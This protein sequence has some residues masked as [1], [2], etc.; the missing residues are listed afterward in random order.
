VL[1][2][3]FYR[4]IMASF[5]RAFLPVNVIEPIA[6][7]NRRDDLARLIELVF[8]TGHDPRLDSE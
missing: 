6:L 3:L 4:E 2:L 8:S 1:P 7:V 5:A